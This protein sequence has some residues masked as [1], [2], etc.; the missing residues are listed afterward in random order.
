MQNICYRRKSEQPKKLETG[1]INKF[2]HSN[3]SGI[4]KY[5]SN[6]TSSNSLP[7]AMSSQSNT[8][9]NDDDT[10]NGTSV[11]IIFTQS[12]PPQILVQTNPLSA[13]PRRGISS[14]DQSRYKQS[15]GIS[16]KVLHNCA[17][18]FMPLVHHKY[19]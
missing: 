18:S 9:E 12:P 3:N 2:T 13:Q 11:F 17:A 14:I 19:I 5:I 10:S 15:S 1:L 7:K 8:F 4:Y 16:A 6:L